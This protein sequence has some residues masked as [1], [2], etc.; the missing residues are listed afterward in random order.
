MTSEFEFSLS[1]IIVNYKSWTVLRKCL[2]SFAEFS[3]SVNYEIIIVDNDSQDGQID[4]FKDTFQQFKFFSNSGNHGFSNGCNFG[5]SRA[6]G[7][8]LLFINPDIILTKSKA[9]DT[10]YNY[11]VNN[12]NVGIISC[13]KI[14]TKGKAEREIAILNLWLNTGWMRALYKLKNKKALLEKY[15]DD[16]EIYH[17]DWVSGSVLFIETD[18][19]H[20][21]E[22]WSQDDFWMYSEDPDLCMK[23][24]H[25]G[26]EIALLRDVELVHFHGGSSRRNYKTIAITKS[27]VVTSHHVYIQ[28]HGRGMNRVLLHVFTLLNTLSAWTIR[29]LLCT[30]VFWKPIFKSSLFTLY[31]ILKYY[32]NALLRGTWKSKRL[33]KYYEDT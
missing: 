4:L 5:A 3:P 32:V 7:K 20:Q 21:V 13:R 15:P 29:T 30:L 31:T 12:P 17:P 33:Q 24:R 6:K 19:F 14:N 22:G 26:K 2:D 23:V 8:Y 18:L 10:M 1:I 28:K 9:I 27:E 16:A 25:L 11:A